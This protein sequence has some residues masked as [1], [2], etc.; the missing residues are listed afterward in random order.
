MD[1]LTPLAIDLNIAKKGELNES[2]LTMFGGAVETVLS[3]MF[4]NTSIPLTVRGTPSQV[5]SFG[6]AL[7]K[8]K[9][10]MEAFK[11]HGLNDPRTFKSR[12]DLEKAVANFERETG[13]KWPF[14]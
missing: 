13:L 7:G 12:H 14:N 6:E 11:K 9:K 10:Y 4:T 8:E 1:K 3:R 5:A 2:W